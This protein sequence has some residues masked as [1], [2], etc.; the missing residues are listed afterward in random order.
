[1]LP[2]HYKGRVYRAI[3]ERT[4]PNNLTS[5]DGEADGQFELTYNDREQLLI[6]DTHCH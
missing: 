3:L 1:M 6:A 5:L 4:W 2:E